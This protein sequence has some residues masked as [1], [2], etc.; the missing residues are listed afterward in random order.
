MRQKFA[1]CELAPA[2][3]ISSS[4]P[5]GV[6]DKDELFEI[7]KVKD[8]YNLIPGDKKEFF[9]MKNATH[10]KIPLESWEEIVAWLNKTFL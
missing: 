7:D 4:E 3:S 2:I 6:G 5:P 10:A 8:F 1:K 9:V